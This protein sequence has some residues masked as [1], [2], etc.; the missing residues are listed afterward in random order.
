MN[1]CN[2]LQ[3]QKIIGDLDN[4]KV[5]DLLSDGLEIL[6]PNNKCRSSKGLNNTTRL[7]VSITT[8]LIIAVVF[9]MRL[10]L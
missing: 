6:D 2:G 10:A 7:H 3:I 1:F 9:C 5:I 8:Y 4:S